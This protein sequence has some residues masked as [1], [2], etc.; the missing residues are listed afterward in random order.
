MT[1]PSLGPI[2]GDRS[3]AHTRVSVGPVHCPPPTG[4]CPPPGI[5]TRSTISEQNYGISF[6]RRKRFS[7]T[8]VTR[9]DVPHF[10]PAK[11]P[12]L[13]LTISPS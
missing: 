1:H 12:L 13:Y 11:L 3:R 4:D 2:I 6:F 5:A 8:K 7:G 10:W 9:T